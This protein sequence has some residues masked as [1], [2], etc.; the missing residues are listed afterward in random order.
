MSSEETRSALLEAAKRLVKDGFKVL[1]YCSD[2]L[3]VCKRL[4]EFYSEW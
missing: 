2:D 1:P 4:A 3:V